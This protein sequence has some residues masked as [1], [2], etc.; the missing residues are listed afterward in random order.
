MAKRKTVPKKKAAPKTSKKKKFT[1]KKVSEL[2]LP[3]EIK[4]S[5]SNVRRI[6]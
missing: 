6:E 1:I 2:T 3:V 4:D 5:V